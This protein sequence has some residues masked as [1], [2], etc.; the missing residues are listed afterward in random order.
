MSSRREQKDEARAAR[1][2]A[3]GDERAAARRRRLQRLAIVAGLA[4]A[5]VAA[6]VAI[7]QSGSDGEEG[8]LASQGAEVE[9][10]FA[11]IPQEGISLGEADAPAVMREF[12][13]PQC[14]FCADYAL[15]VLP[16]IVD[17]YVRPGDLRLELD[18]L[19]FIGPDSERAARVAHAAGEQDRMWEFV[20]LLF[21]NQGAEGS[22]W[23]T[24]ELLRELAEATPG[25]DADRALDARDSEAVDAQLVAS[26]ER[27]ANL[28][29]DST[30]SFFVSREGGQVEPLE[31][32]ALELGAF[33]DQLDPL[34][35][36]GPGG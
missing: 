34:L 35:D 4:V 3:E 1:I 17:R 23:A 18:L 27:A 19:T 6:T 28:R 24:D 11:G 36:G 31:V 21:R 32:S 30:P 29:V 25:L 5:L 2:A 13:D 16:E 22:G 12:A 8:E 33:A 20:E 15:D 10:L 26:Q 14:P 7:T 9:A